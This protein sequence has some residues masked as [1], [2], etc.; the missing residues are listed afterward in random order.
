MAPTQPNQ[1]L[2]RLLKAT[3]LRCFPETISTKD[4]LREAKKAGYK[5]IEV[6]FDGRFDLFCP[7]P[8]LQELKQMASDYGMC[9]VS[10]YSRQ[11][12]KTPISSRDFSRR[13]KGMEAIQWLIEVGA[14]LE[15]PTVLTIPGAVDNSILSPEVEVLPYEEVYSRVQEGLTQL[16]PLAEQ[17]GIILALENVPNKFLLSPLE[18]KRFLEEIKSPAIGCHFD[19]ANCLYSGGY[20]E[21]WIRLLGTHIKAIHVKDYKI[22]VGTLAGFCDIFEGD[23]PWKEVCTSLREI[24]Y[25]GALISEVLPPYKYHPEVLWKSAAIALECL[26]KEILNENYS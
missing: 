16:A 14:F 3:S 11:Q 9:I 21:Q 25:T 5:G 22:S 13:S 23:V 8:V 26:R 12:W 15:A 24:G 6:N 17:A 20:P 2:P 10:V 4:C 1:K 19:I 7:A 18:F